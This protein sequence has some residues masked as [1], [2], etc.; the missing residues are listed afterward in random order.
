LPTGA[1]AVWWR[2]WSFTLKAGEDRKLNNLTFDVS[3]LVGFLVRP[4]GLLGDDAFRMHTFGPSD[5]WGR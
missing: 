1:I 4:G 2:W 5:P 3:V